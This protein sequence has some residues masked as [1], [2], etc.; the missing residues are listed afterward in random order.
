MGQ[1]I[2][3]E[4]FFRI[5]GATVVAYALAALTA[6]CVVES[7]FFSSWNWLAI[8]GPPF[9]ISYIA[10]RSAPQ[11]TRTAVFAWL[12]VVSHGSRLSHSW[13]SC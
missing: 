6:L 12:A 9:A 7:R 2:G 13:A 4:P 11:L 1:T 10:L 5:A 8:L 3:M